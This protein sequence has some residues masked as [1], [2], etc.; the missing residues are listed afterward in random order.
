LQ[1]L[2][3]YPLGNRPD[4]GQAVTVDQAY[5]LAAAERKAG[6]ARRLGAASMEAEEHAVLEA[7]QHATAAAAQQSSPHMEA[8]AR[9]RQQFRDKQEQYWS[10]MQHKTQQQQQHKDSKA[11]GKQLDPSA[12]AGCDPAT[13]AA[14]AAIKGQLKRA[15]NIP[16]FA[17]F[18][19]VFVVRLG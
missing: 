19:S 15:R 10:E 18:V 11:S 7:Q 6:E 8:M 16:S 17:N 2:L 1:A 14:V 12:A 4:L 9:R 5:L 13:A 3:F